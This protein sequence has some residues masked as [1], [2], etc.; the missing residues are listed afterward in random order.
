MPPPQQIHHGSK[1]PANGNN[2]TGMA[3]N[4]SMLGWILWFPPHIGSKMPILARK[5]LNYCLK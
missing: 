4:L 3:M 5:E 2:K 1:Q